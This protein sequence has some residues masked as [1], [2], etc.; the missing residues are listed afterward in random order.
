MVRDANHL[1]I[2]LSGG[3]ANGRLG[4]VNYHLGTTRYAYGAPDPTVA[5]ISQKK[6]AVSKAERK[7]GAAKPAP[8]KRAT[9][10]ITANRPY[11]LTLEFADAEEAL[12]FM[13]KHGLVSKAVR[14]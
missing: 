4:R 6:T 10:V 12:S 2:I 3:Y 8:V 11:T 14:S 1:S 5:M 9:S 7:P 13:F